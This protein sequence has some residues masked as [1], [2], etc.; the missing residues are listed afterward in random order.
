MIFDHSGNV[1]VKNMQIYISW[2]DLNL[3]IKIKQIHWQALLSD[4]YT[5]TKHAHTHTRARMYV[6]QVCVCVCGGG[7]K[8]V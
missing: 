1:I 4:V 6:M 7:G 2:F 3:K 5:G 8:L